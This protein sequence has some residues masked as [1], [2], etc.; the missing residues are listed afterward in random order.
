MR[1]VESRMNLL[2]RIEVHLIE[3]RNGHVEMTQTVVEEDVYS[4]LLH[5]A[6]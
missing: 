2:A 3:H 5:R 1:D 6:M 4:A